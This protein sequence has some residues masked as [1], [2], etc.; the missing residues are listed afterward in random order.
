LAVLGKAYAEVQ[1][2]RMHGYPFFSCLAQT[3]TSQATAPMLQVSVLSG[4]EKARLALAKFM[5]TR[6]SLLVRALLVHNSR[7][8]VIAVRWHIMTHCRSLSQR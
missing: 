1:P 3:A 5:L 4:G 7:F 8:L 6:G 2:V